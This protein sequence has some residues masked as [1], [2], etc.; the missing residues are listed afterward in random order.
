MF[1]EAI[2]DILRDQCTPAVVRAIEAGGSPQPLWDSIAGAG[3]LDLLAPEEA[4]GAALPLPELF[5]VLMHFGRYTVPVP[6]AQA[7]A[8]RAL[9]VGGVALPQGL[10]TLASVL[11][12]APDG[13]LV[14]PL[15]PFGTIAQHV[16]AAQGDQLLLLDAAQARR[17]PSGIAHS[18][19]ATLTWTGRDAAQAIDGDGASLAPLA[20]AVHAALLAG[21]MN[22]VFEM[23]LQYCN[24]RVQFGKSLGKFQAVQHQLSV[25]AE[26]V[27]AAGIGAEAAFQS[28]GRT[29][30]LLPAAMAKA[31]AS[32]AAVTV[33]NTSHGLHGAIGVTDEYDL[34]LLTRRLHEWRMAHGSESYWNR[35]VG[36]HVLAADTTLCEFIRAANDE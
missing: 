2:E 3:F 18:Q 16:L 4:G 12:R 9:V 6:A 7:I 33:A 23:T 29:P 27:A 14:A 26:Q 5:P 13:S 1:A 30:R 11:Q 28:E 24:D 21:A 34:Q 35:L 36:E 17:D 31:R 22:R 19:L 8:A 20:A 15:V 25:M 10:L 32:E